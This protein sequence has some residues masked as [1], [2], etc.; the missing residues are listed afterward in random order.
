MPISTSKQIQINRFHYDYHPITIIPAEKQHFHLQSNDDVLAM[1]SD[2]TLAI[3]LRS[4]TLHVATAKTPSRYDLLIPDPL[5]EVLKLPP[6]ASKH[7]VTLRIHENPD[8]VIP[9]L[10]FTRTAPSHQINALALTQMAS[11][12]HIA[13]NTPSTKPYLVNKTQIAKFAKLSPSAIR[14]I[15][16][17]E[18]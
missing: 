10:M 14:Q 7:M 3:L 13:H 8:I 16:N 5:F 15:G 6:I 18:R 2:N 4:L 1:I 11:R 17:Q 12:F 9:T